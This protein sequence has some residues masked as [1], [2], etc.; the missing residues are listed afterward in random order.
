VDLS[1]IANNFSIKCNN[2]QMSGSEKLKP[3]ILERDF[4][5]YILKVSWYEYIHLF[6]TRLYA[7]LRGQGVR[8]DDF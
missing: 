4:H 2:N 7:V 6:E 3:T 8:V 5:N 1:L